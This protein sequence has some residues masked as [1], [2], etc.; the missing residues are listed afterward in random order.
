MLLKQCIYVIG[1]YY[2]KVPDISRHQLGKCQCKKNIT[3]SWASSSLRR[4]AASFC[5]SSAAICFLRTDRTSWFL[6]CADC[7]SLSSRAALAN[8]KANQLYILT[9]EKEE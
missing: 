6:S 4:R 9:A 7:A 8:L 5:S 3:K 1:S 2:D